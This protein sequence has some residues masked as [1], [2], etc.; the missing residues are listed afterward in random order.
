V[1]VLKHGD[2]GGPQHPTGRISVE[3]FI[4]VLQRKLRLAIMPNEAK[5]LF[6][7]Y[8][9]DAQG[10]LPYELFCRRLFRCALY[11][12]PMPAHPLPPKYDL[13]HLLL[14]VVGSPQSHIIALEGN[15]N[16][17]FLADE[18]SRWGHQGSIK[19]RPN[20]RGVYAPSDWKDVCMEKCR[21]SVRCCPACF[22]ACCGCPSC[23]HAGCADASWHAAHR[24]E[25]Q[26]RT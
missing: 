16:K 21:M 4:K 1:R 15:R 23:V 9:H 2:H 3:K 12:A 24:L 19:A 6:R 14:D 7:K 13:I 18:P 17:P 8:G 11:P 22:C 10:R 25:S 20:K 5:A 26:T